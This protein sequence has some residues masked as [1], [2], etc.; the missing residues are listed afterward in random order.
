MSIKSAC[1]LTGAFGAAKGECMSTTTV[2]APQSY[3]VPLIAT[4]AIV[5]RV[6]GGDGV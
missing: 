6:A 4:A 5:W 2:A 1:F 3:R